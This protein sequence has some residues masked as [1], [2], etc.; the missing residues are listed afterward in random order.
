MARRKLT[1]EEQRE[2]HAFSLRARIIDGSVSLLTTAIRWGVLAYFAWSGV[3]IVHDI[4]GQQTSLTILLQFLADLKVDRWVA[5]AVSGGSVYY[6][7]RQRRLRRDAVERLS[8][9]VAELEQRLDKRRT[10]SQLTSRGDTRPE[11]L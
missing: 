5:Y 9:R 7:Y 10:S 3:Q 8:G 6:G 1:I 2:A 4:A 11:D